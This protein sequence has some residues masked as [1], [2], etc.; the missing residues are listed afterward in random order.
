MNLQENIYRIKEV[1]GIVIESEE[2]EYAVIEITKPIARM[3]IKY[4]YQE[5][6][7]WKTKEEMIYIKKGASGNKMISTKNIKVLK[8]F[9]NRKDPD[10]E[11]YLEKLRNKKD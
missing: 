4:Y 5:V 1:M 7:Y 3:D 8:V 9:K 10:M 11:K 6:P 2:T